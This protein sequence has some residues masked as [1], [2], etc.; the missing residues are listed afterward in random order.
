VG[1]APVVLCRCGEP[2]TAH[3]LIVSAD[4]RLVGGC[5]LSACESFED[6]T[7]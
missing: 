4:D 6:A 7:A 5:G 3:D 1:H 2:S